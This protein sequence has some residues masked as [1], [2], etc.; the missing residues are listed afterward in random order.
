MAE[1][2]SKANFTEIKKAASLAVEAVGKCEKAAAAGVELGELPTRCDG[3]RQS[4]QQFL[5]I[6]DVGKNWNVSQATNG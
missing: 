2:L 1:P 3:L 6:Y 5:D 4:L